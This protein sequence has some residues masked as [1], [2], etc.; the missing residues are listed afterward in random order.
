MKTIQG[1][2]STWLFDTGA[3]VTVLAMREFRKIPIEKRPIKKPPTM[4]VSSASSDSLK[5]V[6]VYELPFTVMNKT[7]KHDVI[8]V[9]NLNSNAIM[10]I[11]LIKKLGLVYKARKKRFVFE[12]EEPHFRQATMEV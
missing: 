1:P 3:D 10:G 11:D 8:V 2:T 7:V 9:N 5:I 4:K 12:D 6:G